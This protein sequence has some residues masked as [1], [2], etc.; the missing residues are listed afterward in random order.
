[1]RLPAPLLRRKENSHKNDFGHVLVLAGSK[2]MMG[3]AALVSL[4]AMR[5]GAGLVTL[6][7]P[8][9]LNPVA[10]KKISSVVMTFPLR[11]T[12][13]K[14]L[15]SAAYAQITKRLKNFDVIALGPGLS[16]NKNT[17]KL[18]AKL[19]STVDKPLVIDADALNAIASNP[20]L[21]KK[22]NNTK[23]LTPHPGEMARLTGLTKN[24]IQTH[25]A[26]AAKK[27]AKIYRCILLLKGKKTVVASAG[28]EVYLNHSGN[29]GLATAGSGDVLTGMI[30]AF[31][32]QGLSGFEAAKYGSYI[33]GLAGDLA[34]N[35]KTKTAMIASDI[36]EK[37]PSALR[38]TI[39]GK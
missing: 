36:I 18:I 3:A 5:S 13:E 35:E 16:Q 21:L 20:D 1:M 37:I 12:R 17:Q 10:Q 24:A 11:E 26:Q 14:T 8:E 4:A 2:S 28:G 7:V 39:K 19:I 27:F 38:L 6:G 25:R 23:I 31:L 22:I 30:A 9:S 32:A 29:V 34:A 15:S 33:H